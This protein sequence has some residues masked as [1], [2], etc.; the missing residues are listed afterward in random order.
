MK[1]SLFRNEKLCVCVCDQ[2]IILMVISWC[3]TQ[4]K[5][6]QINKRSKTKKTVYNAKRD[7][8][9]RKLC[10]V[11]RGYGMRYW[12]DNLYSGNELN[13][14]EIYT[15]KYSAF[16]SFLFS[17]AVPIETRKFSLGILDT[18]CACVCVQCAVYSY[19]S[20]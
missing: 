13:M 6:H 8:T 20:Q 5:S 4:N 19:K 17:L 7:E 1:Y 10:Q 9:R 14:Y 3:Y 18:A 12:E 15:L 16:L 11:L 2:L